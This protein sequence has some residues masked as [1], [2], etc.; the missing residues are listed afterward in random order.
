[1]FCVVS[2]PH[3]E[4][5]TVIDQ[6]SFTNSS[7]SASSGP[8]LRIIE[9]YL[10]TTKNVSEKMY[11]LLMETFNFS[12][13]I[14]SIDSTLDGILALLSL[15]PLCMLLALDMHYSGGIFCMLFALDMYTRCARIN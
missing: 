13:P 2:F 10:P 8:M 9:N 5:I 1:M 3:E 7:S 11:L 15:V 6:L 12:M 14:L 4:K